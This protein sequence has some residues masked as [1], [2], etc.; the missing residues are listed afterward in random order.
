MA[1]LSLNSTN[2]HEDLVFRIV[3]DDDGAHVV[4]L[5]KLLKI[6]GAHENDNGERVMKSLYIHTEDFDHH[7]QD[8]VKRL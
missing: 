8:F 7:Y 1:N 4:E 6:T 2:S 5:M 3:R